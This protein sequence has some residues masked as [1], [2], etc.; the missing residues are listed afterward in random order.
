MTEPLLSDDLTLYPV[1]HEIAS[2]P[3]LVLISDYV[4]DCNKLT[5]RFDDAKNELA[6]TENEVE[7]LISSPTEAKNLIEA[8]NC[9]RN[10]AE[11]AI[12]RFTQCLGENQVKLECLTG[13]RDDADYAVERLTKQLRFTERELDNQ[14]CKP[15]DY[16]LD[17]KS[18]EDFN[19]HRDPD[20]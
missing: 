18:N 6:D 13:Y 14:R 7:D 3:N 4:Q 20:E 9:Y 2:I 19:N 1:S 5:Q 16:S 8:L 10:D 11:S 17:G 15:H 12:K